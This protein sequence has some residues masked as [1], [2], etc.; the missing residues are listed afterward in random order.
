MKGASIPRDLPASHPCPITVVRG[1]KS[2]VE[3]EE[4]FPSTHEH[5][6]RELWAVDPWGSWTHRPE[7]I[8]IIFSVL[9]YFFYRIMVLK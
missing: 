8:D 5:S 9:L 2:L 6:G 4:T 1:E 3:E 7:Y